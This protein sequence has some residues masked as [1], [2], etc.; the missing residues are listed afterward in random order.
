M[1][2][3]LRTMNDTTTGD[4]A[5]VEQIGEFQRMLPGPDWLVDLRAAALGKFNASEWP[6]TSEEEWRRT[7]L[8][9]FEFDLYRF[10]R[11]CIEAALPPL[12]AP[13]SET[14]LREGI[15]GR[16]EVDSGAAREVRVRD[17]LRDAGVVFGD[18]ASCLGDASRTGGDRAKGAMVEAVRGAMERS[19]A[20][21]DNRLQYWHFAIVSNPV[22][23]YVPAGVRIDEPF[24]VALAYAGDEVVYAPHLVVVLEQESSATVVRRISSTEEGEVLLV[25]GSELLVGDGARL[26]YTDL[27]QMNDEALVFRNDRGNVGRDGHIHRTDAALGADFVKTRY[28]SELTGPGADAVLNGLYFAVDEQHMDVRTVQQHRAPHTTSRA[29]YRGAVGDESHAIYQGLIQVDGT[30]R[31]TDAYL[32]NKNLIL[33]ESAR[34]DSIPSLNIKTDD[35]R[36]SHGSTTGKI[37]PDQVFYLGTRGYSATEALR[38]LVEGHFEDLIRQT[39][40]SIQDELRALIIARTPEEL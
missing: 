23:L 18:L 9:P 20:I 5:A 21:A 40:E 12:V 28:V 7:N 6:T 4:L 25:D 29:H 19:L 33:G 32:T 22:V 16:L 17:D 11:T 15:A 14:P 34:A 27:M 38:M 31:G 39:P 36:C 8:S 24:E 26:H 37:D 2:P 35:V 30:A 1:S 3:A 10:P 13:E